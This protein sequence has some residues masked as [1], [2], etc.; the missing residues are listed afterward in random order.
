MDKFCFAN[1]EEQVKKINKYFSVSMVIFDALILGCSDIGYS[2]QPVR[3][4]R[5][6]DGSYY[7]CDLYFL[8][9]HFG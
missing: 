5:C 2:G 3:G 8:F 4:I 6:S 9:C 7:A 1:K